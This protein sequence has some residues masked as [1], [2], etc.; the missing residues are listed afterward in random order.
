MK[1]STIIIGLIALMCFCT[2]NICAGNNDSES[3]QRFRFAINGGYGQRTAQVTGSM[4]PMY[5]KDLPT[6]YYDDRER[7]SGFHLELGAAY[8]FTRNFG[9]GLK[10]SGVRH[11]E[12]IVTGYIS[13]PMGGN[14]GVAGYVDTHLWTYFTTPTLNYRIFLTERFLLVGDFAMGYFSGA[15]IGERPDVRVSAFAGSMSLGID[16]LLSSSAILRGLGFQMSLMK[17][18]PTKREFPSA[19]SLTSEKISFQGIDFSVGL[20]F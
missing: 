11:K 5:F 13:P 19:G 1:K 10:Y 14:P 12:T 3:F 2:S 18:L 17:G 15:R 20:R 8:F 7:K 9:V 6:F 4:T 16:V